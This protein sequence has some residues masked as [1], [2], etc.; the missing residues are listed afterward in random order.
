[1]ASRVA[2]VDE[3]RLAGRVASGKP[4]VLPRGGWR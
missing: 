4:W 2:A 1:M 3:A